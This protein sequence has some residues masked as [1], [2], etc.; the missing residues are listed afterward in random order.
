MIQYTARDNTNFPSM[1]NAIYLGI[2][3]IDF[4]DFLE[5]YRRARAYINWRGNF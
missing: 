4:V 5:K 3:Q 1:N 2:S